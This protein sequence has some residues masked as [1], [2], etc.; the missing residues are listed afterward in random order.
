[1]PYA[2]KPLK[3]GD[4]IEEPVGNEEPEEPVGPVEQDGG[5]RRG[6]KP[7]AATWKRTERKVKV[8][9]G[10]GKSAKTVSKTVYKNSKTGEQRVRKM[11]T[12]KGV[13]VATYVKF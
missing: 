11:A 7:A 2:Y 3:G 13:R 1:M 4:Q 5:A 9:E 10:R 8:T 12:R 6:K